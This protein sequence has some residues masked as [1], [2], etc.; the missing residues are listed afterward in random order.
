VVQEFRDNPKRKPNASLGLDLLKSRIS[1]WLNRADR[2]VH[3]KRSFESLEKARDLSKR[4]RDFKG[5][6]KWWSAVSFAAVCMALII[7]AAILAQSKRKTFIY[8][9]P[10]NYLRVIS[11]V[12]PCDSDGTCGYR[13]VVQA[14]VNGVPY[15]ETEMQFCEKPR[16][17]QGHTLAWIQYTNT[18]ECNSVDGFDVVRGADLLPTLPA[19][20]NPDY[21]QAK[22]AGHIA[23]EGGRARF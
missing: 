16:F 7:G 5:F 9:Y 19:N 1:Y 23:C 18:G 6:T 17:E 10:T 15:P 13:R 22:K 14:V 20:C 8:V 4:L 12:E 2:E 11:N 3:P 21:S